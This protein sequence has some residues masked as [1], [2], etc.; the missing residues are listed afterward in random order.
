MNAF[1]RNYMSNL[2]DEFL[3]KSQS[4]IK[5]E[6]KQNNSK[7]PFSND[8][9]LY[10]FQIAFFEFCGIPKKEIPFFIQK[11][12][13]S[14]YFPNIQFAKLRKMHSDSIKFISDYLNENFPSV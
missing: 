14:N 13:Y 6:I 5:F 2:S 1:F 7:V 3:S 4:M 9:F 10:I 11:I 8:Y 12:N